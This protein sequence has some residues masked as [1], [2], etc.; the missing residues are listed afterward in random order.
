MSVHAETGYRERMLA[1]LDAI[2]RV[3]DG[4][5]ELGRSGG[6]LEKLDIAERC[7]AVLCDHY[8]A[9]FRFSAGAYFLSAGGVRARCM[10]SQYLLLRRWSAA[11]SRVPKR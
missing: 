3:V 2:V 7:I 10:G 11:A 6:R 8:G 4:H 9:R 1:R 5:I